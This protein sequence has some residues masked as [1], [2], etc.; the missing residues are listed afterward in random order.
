M[1][2]QNGK[3]ILSLSHSGDHHLA[4]AKYDPLTGR[5]N[6]GVIYSFSDN[7]AASVQIVDGKT[8]GT[9]QHSGDTH[10]TRIDMSSD[11]TFTGSFED[12]TIGLKIEMR[13]GGA[14][15]TSG[16]IPVN[17]INIIADHHIISLKLDSNNRICGSIESKDT[18]YGDFKINVDQGKISGCLTHQGDGHETS[19]EVFPDGKWSAS[20]SAGTPDSRWSVGVEN[21]NAGMQVVA[22]LKFGF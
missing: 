10:K 7:S 18:Q 17:G 6:A 19:I 5:I 3:Q 9:F 4:E 15:V 2:D 12:T 8:T 11:G 21:G 20:L 14:S 16:K 13:G 22:G 1:V